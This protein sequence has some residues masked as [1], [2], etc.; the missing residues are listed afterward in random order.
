M[1][2]L[3]KKLPPGEFICDMCK[4]KH[5][6]NKRFIYETFEV[7]PH[8]PSKELTICEK[9]AIRESKFKNKKQFKEYFEG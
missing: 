1:Y 4:A 2:G 5:F 7:L 3:S 9:C 6:H 8:C